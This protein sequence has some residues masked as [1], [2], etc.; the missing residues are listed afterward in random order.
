MKAKILVGFWCHSLYLRRVNVE[1]ETRNFMETA[2][3]AK[4]IIQLYKGPLYDDQKKEWDELLTYFEDARNYLEKIGLQ[5][6]LNENE[7]FAY[8]N[9]IQSDE[10]PLPRIISSRKLSWEVT[11]LCV[12]LRQKLDEFDV[13]NMESRKLFLSKS[14]L[15]AEI[16]LFIDENNNRSRLLDKLDSYIKQV[17]DLG[18]LKA[19]GTANRDQ[20]ERTRYEVRRIIKARFSSDELQQILNKIK[21]QDESPEDNI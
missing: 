7:G 12:L 6:I 2:A 19:V 3:F 17:V 15:K 8:L 11:L 4:T 14:E 5:L 9:Q 18:Y 1:L 20:P 10:R 16:E 13:K 21:P